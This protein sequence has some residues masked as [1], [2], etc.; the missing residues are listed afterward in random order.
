MLVIDFDSK[1]QK[2]VQIEEG[3]VGNT[4]HGGSGAG[5]LSSVLN[6][7][8]THIFSPAQGVSPLVSAG[9]S[10]LIWC[11]K[12]G[13]SGRVFNAL[14]VLTRYLNQK[15]RQDHVPLYTRAALPKRS[16]AG[17]GAE[18]VLWK[19]ALNTWIIS[20]QVL[21]FCWVV[22][23]RPPMDHS[24]G[25]SP[26]STLVPL[27]HFCF[28]NPS[29]LDLLFQKF[30]FSFLSCAGLITNQKAFNGQSDGALGPSD[31]KYTLY[32]HWIHGV[33]SLEIQLLLFV[34]FE[35]RRVIHFLLDTSRAD[36]W[37]FLIKQ[38]K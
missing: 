32:P 28:H 14:T 1:E 17:Q 18:S 5:P 20:L 19:T 37:G 21:R 23:H 25:W 27:S 30:S 36:N 35:E 31:T 33:R 11:M 22:S 2:L 13:S 38:Q 26:R 7:G 6:L 12:T 15:D 16:S 3:W 24:K 29:S 34:I 4:L 8:C 9:I 10:T